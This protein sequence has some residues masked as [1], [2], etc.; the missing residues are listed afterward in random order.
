MLLLTLALTLTSSMSAGPVSSP[1][2]PSCS[3]VTEE[4]WGEVA[5]W[6]DGLASRE[7]VYTQTGL[8]GNYTGQVVEERREGWGE[9]RWN[10]GTLYGPDNIFYYSLGDRYLGE[11]LQGLQAGVGTLVTQTGLY[12]G[13]WEDGLQVGFFLTFHNEIISIYKSSTIHYYAVR[14]NAY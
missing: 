2:S 8:E 11:W 14:G 7:S 5:D 10:N 12:V 6:L 1:S 9:M 4:R 13:Y 3:L